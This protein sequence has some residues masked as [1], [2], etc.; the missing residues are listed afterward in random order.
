L[1]INYIKHFSS[2]NY[3]QNNEIVAVCS[4]YMS[5]YL[6]E[7]LAGLGFKVDH[8]D[9]L[10]VT[11]TG[12]FEDTMKMNLYLRTANR[13]LFL[14]SRF[15]AS[16]PEEMYDQ[17]IKTSW[18]EWMD[19]SGYVHIHSVVKNETIRDNRF[20]NLKLKDAIADYFM[21]KYNVRPDS[22]PE[23]NRTVV[24]LHWKE[25]E[26]SIYLDTS[27]ETISK[28]GYRVNP[29]K[30]PMIE[31]LAAGVIMETG[32][33]VHGNF[34]NP[35]C[36]SGTLA[37]EAALIASDT[38]PGLLRNN[39]GFM[40]SR[41]YDSRKWR[42]LIDDAKS[43]VKRKIPVEIIASDR[44]S[45]AIEAAKANAEKAGMAKH[46]DFLRC[47]YKFSPIPDGGG[48]VILNPEYGLRLG[49]VNQLEITYQEIGDFFKKKCVG[50]TGYVFSGNLD[51][52][53]KIGLRAAKKT[54]FMNGTIDSRLLRYELYAGSH[55]TIDV[56]D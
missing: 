44:E 50:Y 39:F 42:L 46:I 3:M 23:K 36:G 19:K 18:D 12:S 51:L 22:G 16:N 27:G 56:S 13:V 30:A 24:F 10:T 1:G 4:P 5:P 35:M 49:E 8:A 31:S 7:E 21:N 33:K 32:W 41:L 43:R 40:H 20:A 6:S 38:A 52:V 15:K 28:H 26:C 34:V 14:I 29:W 9:H 55:R 25:T 45:L 54:Q 47:D 48:T 2:Q 11:T 37:I 53:K 17:A